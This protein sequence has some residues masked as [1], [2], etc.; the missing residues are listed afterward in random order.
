MKP[1][2][3]PG[4][5]IAIQIAACNEPSG[6][7]Q[8]GNDSTGPGLASAGG[9][10]GGAPETSSGQSGGGGAP[11]ACI[12]DFPTRGDYP[13]EV[14]AVLEAKCFACHQ[15]PPLNDAPFSFATYEDTREPFLETKKRWQRMAEVIQ[16]VEGQ[17]PFMPFFTAPD[18][19]PSEKATLEAWF[20][21]CAPPGEP[22]CE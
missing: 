8:G 14:F 3:L 9:G 13:C 15:D 7:D 2:A 16:P 5:L 22:G 1:R 21:A 12:D 17:P 20:K 11:A 10:A 19:A 4:W 6:G 18:L